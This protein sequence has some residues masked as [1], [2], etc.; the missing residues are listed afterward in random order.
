MLALARGAHGLQL[1]VVCSYSA[2][3]VMILSN[4]TVPVAFAIEDWE[5]LRKFSEIFPLCRVHRNVPCV[6]V[7]A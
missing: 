7:V 1:V 5:F 4:F 6:L 2:I 3:I